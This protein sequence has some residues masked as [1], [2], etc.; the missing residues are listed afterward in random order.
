MRIDFRSYRRFE[1][2]LIIASAN[3]FTYINQSV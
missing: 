3:L 2:S 1:E